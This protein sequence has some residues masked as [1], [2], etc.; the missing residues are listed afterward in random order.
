MGA[1]FSAKRVGVPNP[2][3]E[4]RDGLVCCSYE[5]CNGA[6]LSEMHNS[7]YSQIF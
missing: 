5:C 7:A 2:M 6:E 3:W 4:R 1:S